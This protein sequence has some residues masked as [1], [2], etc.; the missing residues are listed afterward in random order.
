MTMYTNGPPY[1]W[2]RKSLPFLLLSFERLVLL[3]YTARRG[4]AVKLTS[5]GKV[6]SVDASS[7]FYCKVSWIV[8]IISMDWHVF[9]RRGRMK[10][11]FKN[12]MATQFQIGIIFT[13][14]VSLVSCALP[15]KKGKTTNFDVLMLAYFTEHF[16]YPSCF[17]LNYQRKLR[18]FTAVSSI[19]NSQRCRNSRQPCLGKNPGE[20]NSFWLLH[21]WG[22]LWK[23]V[24]SQCI[25]LV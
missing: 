16:W 2:R 15:E 25:I 24:N 12:T 3:S 10:T 7:Q 22:H 17:Y 11:S 18:Y 20:N 4:G 9:I 21:V 6:P 13:S 14:L 1:G 8:H 5:K 19:K 23:I